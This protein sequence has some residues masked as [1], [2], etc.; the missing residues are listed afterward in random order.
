[1]SLDPSTTLEAAQ[2]YVQERMDEGVPCPCCA[3][4]C[5]VYRRGMTGSQAYILVLLYHHTKTTTDWIYLPEFLSQVS[6]LS[7]AARGGDY[8]KL[9][10]WGLIAPKLDGERRADGSDRLGF[11]KITERGKLFVEGKI[12]IPKYI[13]VYNQALLRWS[14]DATISIRDALGKKFSYEELMSPKAEDNDAADTE[15]PATSGS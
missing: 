12:R 2:R 4:F 10:F 15:S 9:C 1:M 5:K 14:T 6:E 13:Y 3:Q 11:Y 8:G 7:A